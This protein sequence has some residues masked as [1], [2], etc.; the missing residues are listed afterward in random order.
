VNHFRAFV[1]GFVSTLVFHQAV[2]LVFNLLGAI[3]F[4]PW[5][6]APTQPLGVPAVISL[7]FWGG[8][9]GVALWPLL[10]GAAGRAYWIRAVVLGALGPT[11]VAFLIVAPMKGRPIGMGW[12]P[13]LWIGGFIVNAAWGYGLAL[14]LRTF[15]RFGL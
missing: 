15:K 12:D 1:A 4:G 8:V 7:A 14:L 9:W 10:R 5:S 11:L 2:I 13:K 3:P 6:M